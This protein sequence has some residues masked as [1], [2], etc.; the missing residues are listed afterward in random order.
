M[1]PPP[2]V[3]LVHSPWKRTTRGYE[4]KKKKRPEL[5]NTHFEG[6]SLPFTI[7]KRKFS[8]SNFV[9]IS[10]V[11]GPHV[12]E[13]RPFVFE[14]IAAGNN[15]IATFFQFQLCF[16]YMSIFARKTKLERKTN[17]NF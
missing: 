9:G 11:C 15:Y 5:K 3:S 14:R 8:E 2:A 6:F 7:L 10:S 16:G 1:F 17:S 13:E 4:E 12:Q